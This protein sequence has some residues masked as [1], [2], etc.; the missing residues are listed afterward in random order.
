MDTSNELQYKS[1][2]PIS[3]EKTKQAKTTTKLSSVTSGNW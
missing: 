1:F 2:E 3:L